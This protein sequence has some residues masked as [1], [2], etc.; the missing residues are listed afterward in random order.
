MSYTNNK[1][2]RA[3]AETKQRLCSDVQ[4][5][6]NNCLDRFEAEAFFADSHFNV[7]AVVAGREEVM[8]TETHRAYVPP[9][10]RRPKGFIPLTKATRGS[11]IPHRELRSA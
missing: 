10:V 5:I 11:F 9:Q 6:L 1:A 4:V 2:S 3:P 7:D 8:I